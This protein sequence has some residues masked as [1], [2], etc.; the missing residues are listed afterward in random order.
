[1]V[2]EVGGELVPSAEESV[3][4]DLLLSRLGFNGE[5]HAQLREAERGEQKYHC[6]AKHILQHEIEY[7]QLL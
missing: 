4:R 2:F 3:G 1:M 7:S 5:G 6:K